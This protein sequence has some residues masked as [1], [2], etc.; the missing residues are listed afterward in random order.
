MFGTNAVTHPARVRQQ[1]V[2]FA[3]PGGNQGA[4]K[5]NRKRKIG[6]PMSVQM[7]DLALVQ[8][9]FD[10]AEAVCADFYTVPVGDDVNDAV[11]NFLER[12][13]YTAGMTG[14]WLRQPMNARRVPYGRNPM[15][16]FHME[17]DH[18]IRVATAAR[19]L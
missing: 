7:S 2:R 17:F 14:G 10:A 9:K 6:L 15:F 5:A 4:A 3:A 11:F 12:H 1:V 13:I 19:E 18:T 8:S 16:S